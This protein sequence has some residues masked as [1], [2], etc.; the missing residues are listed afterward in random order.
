MELDPT[1][2]HPKSEPDVVRRLPV[3]RLSKVMQRLVDME[4]SNTKEARQVGSCQV[5]K[6]IGGWGLQQ[7]ALSFAC[8]SWR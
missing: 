5:G 1:A 2:K 4:R 3:M 7:H 8:A 6:P